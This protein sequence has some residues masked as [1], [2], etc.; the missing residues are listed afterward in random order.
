MH[1]G[2]QGMTQKSAVPLLANLSSSMQ[3]D[4]SL[5]LS[6]SLLPTTTTPQNVL[7]KMGCHAVTRCLMAAYA[8]FFSLLCCGVCDGAAM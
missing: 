7:H 4:V 6:L 3:P 2:W 1:Y 5:S 8:P